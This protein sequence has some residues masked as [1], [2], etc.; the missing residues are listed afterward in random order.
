MSAKALHDYTDKLPDLGIAEL[1]D[2]PPALGTSTD[3]AIASGLYWGAVG[4]IQAL[5]RQLNKEMSA[6]PYVVLTGGAAEQVADLLEV[7]AAYQKHLVLA[8]MALTAER[9]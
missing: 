9:L 4:A 7:S 5:I 6:E 3:E 1:D 8:G 2:P